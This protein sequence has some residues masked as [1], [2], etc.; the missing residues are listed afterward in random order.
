M[1]QMA[2]MADRDRSSDLRRSTAGSIGRKDVRI[3]AFGIHLRPSASSADKIR[4]VPQA[5]E[6]SV[7]TFLVAYDISD[8]RRLRKVARAREDF[9][10]RRQYSVF[11]CLDPWTRRT[12]ESGV[13]RPGSAWSC[14]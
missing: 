14:G 2:Q 8:P 13:I 1:T 5:E 9:G 11:S 6:S 12:H 4:S 7:E 3:S 10:L